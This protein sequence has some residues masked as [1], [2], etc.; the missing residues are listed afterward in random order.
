MIYDIES[1]LTSFFLSEKCVCMRKKCISNIRASC[2]EL[3]GLLLSTDR[4]RSIIFGK[5]FQTLKIG[6][7]RKNGVFFRSLTP[8]IRRPKM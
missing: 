6:N 8:S 5:S 1:Y 3:H 4:A 2:G 7:E